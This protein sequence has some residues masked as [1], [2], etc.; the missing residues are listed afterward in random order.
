MYSWRFHPRYK[1]HSW[2]KALNRNM[3]LCISKLTSLENAFEEIYCEKYLRAILL[4]TYLFLHGYDCTDS[5]LTNMNEWVHEEMIV[6]CYI[7]HQKSKVLALFLMLLCIS[8]TFL[9]EM[10][11]KMKH[12]SLCMSVKVKFSPLSQRL[13]LISVSVFSLSDCDTAR[14][15][16]ANHIQTLIRHIFKLVSCASLVST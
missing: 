14:N 13:D 6:M 1:T 8:G 12:E 7:P 2:L 3:C 5:T 4:I 16:S 10:F 15:S 9:R 11:S